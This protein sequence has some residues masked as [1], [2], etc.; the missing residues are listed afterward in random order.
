M[1]KKWGNV[2]YFMVRTLLYK[3]HVNQTPLPKSVL[4]EYILISQIGCPT[5]DVENATIKP[6]WPS[7][8]PLAYVS[9]LDDA[10]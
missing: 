6:F 2:T 5:L 7:H 9:Q 3:S 1:S 4:L 8:T 10:D